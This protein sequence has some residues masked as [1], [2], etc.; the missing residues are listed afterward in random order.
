[1][2][3]EPTKDELLEQARELD[4]E[5]RSNMNKEELAQAI[6]EAQADQ[7]APED[8]ERLQLIQDHLEAKPDEHSADEIA[9][10]TDLEV[11]AVRTYLDEYRPVGDGFEHGGPGGGG[12]WVQ[13]E[14]DESITLT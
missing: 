10:A 9:A 11:A 3:D 2:T 6:Q 14:S 13:V 1:M 8:L 7:I 12:P 4:I 5:G